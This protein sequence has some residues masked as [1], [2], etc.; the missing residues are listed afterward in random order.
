MSRTPDLSAG[1]S[2]LNCFPRT[3]STSIINAQPDDVMAVAASYDSTL[4]YGAQTPFTDQLSFKW[5]GGMWEYDPYHSSIITAGNA[6]TKPTQTAFTIFYNQGTQRYDLEQTL[7]PDEQMWIDVGK[8]I[9]EQVPDKNGKVLPLGLTSGSYEF[10]D[11]TDFALG[12]LFEGKVIYDKTYGHVAYGCANCCGTIK[13]ELW[14]DPLGVLFSAT[15]GQGVNGYDNCALTWNDVSSYFE[16]NWLTQSTAIATV[17]F[18]TIL[19]FS[20]LLARKATV[21]AEIPTDSF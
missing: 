2:A 21:R 7:Q 16:G 3:L 20:C 1:A 19:T 17:D 11:L 8:L 6:R 4:R 18:Y 15:A 13:S 5:E 9:R 12:D 10:R 14:L